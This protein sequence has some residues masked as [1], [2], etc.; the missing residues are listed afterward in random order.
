MC[1]TYTYKHTY[2]HTYAHIHKHYI[3]PP[4]SA[5]VILEPY[6]SHWWASVIYTGIPSA[7]QRIERI[8][9]RKYRCDHSGTVVFHFVLRCLHY[10]NSLTGSAITYVGDV[11]LN[12]QLLFLVYALAIIVAY[13]LATS[14]KLAQFLYKRNAPACEYCHFSCKRLYTSLWNQRR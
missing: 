13:T 4:P 2:M 11:L 8:V 6:A 3:P 7:L 14:Q 9:R 5:L 1:L 10:A 12:A